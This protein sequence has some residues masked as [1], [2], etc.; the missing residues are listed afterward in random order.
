MASN[1]L[2]RPSMPATLR[3][4][5]LAAVVA[6]APLGFPQGNPFSGGEVAEPWSSFPLNAK[7]RLQ[8]DYRNSNV[9]AILAM[10]QRASGITIVKDP[11]LVGPLSLSSAKPVPLKDAFAILS[12]TLSLKGYDMRKQGNLLVIRKRDTNQGGG[13]RGFDP[14]QFQNQGQDAN[15]GGDQAELKVYPINYANASQVARVINSVFADSGSSSFGGFRGPFGENLTD[16]VDA[17]PAVQ[18]PGGGGGFGGGGQ[19]GRGGFGGGNQGGGRGGQGGFNPNMMRAMM[20]GGQSTTLVHADYDDYSNQVIVSAPARFQ[21][22]VRTLVSQLDKVTDTPVQTKVYHLQYSSATD[23]VTV[24]QQ[25]LNSNVPRGKGGAGANANQGAGGFFS[26]LRGQ[27]AGSGT[28]TADARTNN[29]VV[30]ATPENVK[31]VDAV[32]KELDQKVNV[33]STT[34]VFQLNN[35]KADDVATLLQNAFGTRTGVNGNRGATGNRTTTS[36]TSSSARNNQTRN[37][38]G[39][40]NEVIGNDVEMAM[41]DPNATSG[42]LATSVGVTQGFGQ[43]FLGGGQGGQGTQ[44]RTGTTQRTF[45][46]DQNG[47]VV[48]TRDLSNQVTAIAD[49]NTNS[50]I[51]VTSPENAEII[52]RI[53]DQLDKIPEQVLIETIIVEAS[54]TAS[55]KLGV[56]FNTANTGNTTTNGSTNFN[57]VGATASTTNDN[58]GFQYT[59]TGTNYGVFLNALKSD[60]KFQVLSTPKIFTS[61][62]VQAS[63]NISQSIPYITSQRQDVNGGLTYAYAFQDVGVVLTVTPRITSNGYVSMDIVQTANDLQGYTS[64][65]APIINQREADTRVSVKDGDTVILGG[66][67]RKTVT[68]DQRKVPIL[69]DV[70]L[71]GQLF[72]SNVKTNAKTE[73][74][75]FMR[76]R[77]V[78][79]A[80]EAQRLRS[81]NEQ[82]MSPETRKSLKDYEQTGNNDSQRVK[83]GDPKVIPIPKP[84]ENPPKNPPR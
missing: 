82:K 39:L 14:T 55:D 74:L 27:T 67:I 73:L 66:I 8:L 38:G 3:A 33:E 36:T 16:A 40:N 45:G 19:G 69:G 64:F 68:T 75:V 50:L 9:D 28:V 32:V 56:T 13:N 34:F 46:V 81:E 54:L 35:A 2:S 52:R 15:G 25:V 12:A 57:N 77:I 60:T 23:V 37:A 21:S 42:E 29:I 48:N 4:A 6:V 49:T 62:G 61:N 51:I 78:K 72:R 83:S 1:R 76:P 5:A 65:N 30:T 71:L 18:F 24:V 47:Q 31:T 20:R 7:T 79:S 59:L 22:Q 41:A 80:E 58:Q 17:A 10:Y 44:G 63:I 26:A 43:G 11:S 70:P 53:L 84:G